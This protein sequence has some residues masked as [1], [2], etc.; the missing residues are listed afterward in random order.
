MSERVI[1]IGRDNSTLQSLRALRTNRTRRHKTGTFVVEGVEPITAAVANGWDC[2]AVIYRSG[3]RLSAWA[4]GVIESASAAARYK[5]TPDLLG[6]L[7]GKTD[8]SE[9]LAVFRMRADDL[10]RVPVHARLLAAV[11]DRPSNCGNLGTVIRSCH[12]FGVQGV[13]ISGHGVDLYDPATVTASRGA[14]FALPVV[15]VA[16]ADDVVVWSASVR[17]ALGGCT[18]VGA[19]TDADCDLWSHDFR[20]PTIVVAGSE[21]AGLS[22]AYRERCDAL[23]RIPMDGRVPSINVGA[24]MSIVLYEAARQRRPGGPPAGGGGS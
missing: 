8:T 4:A 20:G 21:R 1:R 2:E 15:R 24:A 19:E 3:G 22:R 7:S 23:V 18:L 14:L 5:V 6:G 11:F 13:V 9:L 17:D 12:A 10:G 16:A